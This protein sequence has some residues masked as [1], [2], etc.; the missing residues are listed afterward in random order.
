[1]TIELVLIGDASEALNGLSDGHG[2]FLVVGSALSARRR[3]APG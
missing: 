3:P 2:Q 1:M